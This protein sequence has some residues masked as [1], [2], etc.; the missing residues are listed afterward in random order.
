MACSEH[1]HRAPEPEE[2]RQP[3]PRRSRSGLCA[4]SN[5]RHTSGMPAITSAIGWSS[6]SEDPS[7]RRAHHPIPRDVD[8]LPYR[9]ACRSTAATEPP[10]PP[11]VPDRS[12]YVHLQPA[13][14]Q[15]ELSGRRCG[16]VGMQ[17]VLA[18]PQLDAPDLPG[19]RLRQLAELQPPDPLVRG[20]VVAGE[21]QDRPRGL[22]VGLV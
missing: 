11:I 3:E 9:T 12:P 19:D 1:G 7:T 2:G 15:G 4:T 17:L 5:R 22:R 21:L 16:G 14:L 20:E 13:P 18:A 10:P 6:R 8:L